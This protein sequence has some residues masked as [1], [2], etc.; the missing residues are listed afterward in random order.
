MIICLS[1][2]LLVSGTC[3][4][5]ACGLRE[6]RPPAPRR[7]AM[8]RP[9]ASVR[10]R[11]VSLS[12]FP[13]TRF[14]STKGSELSSHAIGSVFTRPKESRNVRRAHG[15]GLTRAFRLV[16]A[17]TRQSSVA[18]LL[19]NI[20]VAMIRSYG[21]GHE[22]CLVGF[23]AVKRSARRRPV[24][25]HYANLCWVSQAHMQPRCMKMSHVKLSLNTRLVLQIG[26]TLSGLGTTLA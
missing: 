2:A 18:L 3:L 13:W 10:T 7:P 17:T 26:K 12:Q 1:E 16:E 19:N 6:G 5:L 9:I 15:D 24:L 23:Y 20:L 25:S 22:R 21:G 8:E 4:V 11:P 14:V